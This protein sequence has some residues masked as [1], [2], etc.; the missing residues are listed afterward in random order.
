ME[1]LTWF[2]PMA[3][4]GA[5]FIPNLAGAADKADNAYLTD[6]DFVAKATEGGMAE[7]MLS[8]LAE[9]QSSD[10]GVKEFAR[11]MVKDQ[12][13]ANEKLAG[14]VKDKPAAAATPSKE[15]KDMRIAWRP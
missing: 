13:A 5:V 3:L 14:I 1:V 4:A 6:R 2:A 10:D 12:T 7:V 8:Q 11:M 9:K 15:V